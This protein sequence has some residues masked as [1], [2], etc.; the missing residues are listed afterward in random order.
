MK[1]TL[2]QAGYTYVRY[3][4]TLKAHILRDEDGKLEL[5]TAN[6]NHAS[7]GLIYKNTHLEFVS[8]YVPFY[9][10]PE[11]VARQVIEE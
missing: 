1:E 11:R 4:K 7:Y 8:S 5:W 3:S 2:Q 6:K 10:V 9:G